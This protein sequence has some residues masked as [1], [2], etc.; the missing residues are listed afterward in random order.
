MNLVHPSQAIENIT[1]N[2]ENMQYVY[3]LHNEPHIHDALN[4][5]RTTRDALI[6]EEQLVDEAF[7]EFVNDMN[8]DELTRFICDEEETET[9][10]EWIETQILEPL[11]DLELDDYEGSVFH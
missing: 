6:V 4:Y 2:I 7:D 1:I 10:L 9:V 11:D 3:Q 8:A 5:A